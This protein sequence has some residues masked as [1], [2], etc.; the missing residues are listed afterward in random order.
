MSATTKPTPILRVLEV[1]SLRIGATADTLR[2]VLADDSLPLSIIGELHGYPAVIV[3]TTC[4]AEQVAG[5]LPADLAVEITELRRHYPSRPLTQASLAAL[6]AEATRT[7]C[8]AI[9]A[10]A[11]ERAI[12]RRRLELLIIA[13][14]ITPPYRHLLRTVIGRNGYSGALTICELTQVQLGQ[15][16]GVRRAGCIGLLRGSR[17]VSF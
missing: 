10:T 17:H 8:L 16:A 4:E 6:L 1:A 5:L 7:R 12:Q 15:A 2:Q 3:E 13:T 11:I 14:D 9:G